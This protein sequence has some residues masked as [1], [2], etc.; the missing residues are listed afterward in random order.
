[1]SLFDDTHTTPLRFWDQV[2]QSTTKLSGQ[3]DENDGDLTLL[4]ETQAKIQEYIFKRGGASHGDSTAVT[5]RTISDDK[6]EN[7]ETEAMDVDP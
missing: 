6:A 4:R 1:M 3:E 5:S 7:Q 2:I